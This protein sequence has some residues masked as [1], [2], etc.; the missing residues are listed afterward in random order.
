MASKEISN[1]TRRR[2]RK[3]AELLEFTLVF[4][5]LISMIMVLV[6]LSWAVFAKATM[7]QAVRYGVR[8]GVTITGSQVPTGSDLTTMVKDT[9][10]QHSLWL[11]KGTNRSLIKVNFFKP[12]DAGT[13]NPMTDVTAASDGN[14]A[15]NIMQV[16]VQGYSLAPLVDR[17]LYPPARTEDN[18]LTV[19][20]FAADRIEPSRDPPPKGAAP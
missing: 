8:V 14:A 3:G 2:A 16:S 19:K 20:V 12:P 4:L 11:L 9:V 15:G 1:S 18:A 6:D 10:Q 5:P 13:S 17:L 7:Q